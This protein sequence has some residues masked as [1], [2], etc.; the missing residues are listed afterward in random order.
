MILYDIKKYLN[1][2]HFF[3]DIANTKLLKKLHR[4]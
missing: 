4:R 3:F 1:K 2:D